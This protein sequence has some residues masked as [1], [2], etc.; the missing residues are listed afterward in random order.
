MI[1]IYKITNPKGK[2]YI[3][4]SIDI[5]RRFREYNKLQCCKD[6]KK[7][8]YSLTKYSP[9]SHTFEVLEECK[10]EDLENREVFW[11]KKFNSVNK[12]LNIKNG[13]KPQW[14]GKKR[15]EHSKFLIENGSGLSY[16]RTQKHKEDLS[17]IM[18]AVWAEKKEEIGK[19]ITKGKI[20]KGTKAVKC[21]TLDITFESINEASKALDVSKGQICQ[22][23]KGNRDYIKGLTFIYI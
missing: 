11:I 5:P 13:S 21:T 23:V 2:V 8:Y 6:S 7:L 22:V 1:G 12:G 19:K 18:K 9:S 15:P 17:K 16:T 3:G 10:I 14:S 4:Q 20:G